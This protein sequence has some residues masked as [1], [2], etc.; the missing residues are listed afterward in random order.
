M[1]SLLK[2]HGYATAAVG[3]WHLGYGTA[4]E[5]PKW[6]TDYTAELSPG[7]LDIGFDY[8]FGVPAN[9]GDLTGVYVE[10]RFVYGLRSGKIPA[11]MKPCRIRARTRMISKAT[12]DGGGHGKSEGRCRILELDAPRRKN[13]RV[14][15]VLTDKATHGWSS[16]RK[17]RPFF[18]YFTPVAVHNPVTPDK[19]IAG[20]SAAGLY[21]DWIHELDRSVGGFWTRSTSR[22]SAKDTLVIFTSDNG[23]VFKTRHDRLLQT[24]RIEGGACA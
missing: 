2:K 14:M 24:T 8:H 11:G 12:Y 3:K 10:N 22:V 17:T 9:H 15:T 20:K 16:S 19:D 21:G 4:D 1:A 13:E 23:G 18:L 6:R 7:P 5:S